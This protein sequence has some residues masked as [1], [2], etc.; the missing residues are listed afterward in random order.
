M[1]VILLEKVLKLGDPGDL[2]NVRKGYARNFLIPQ[3]KA[4]RADD[5]NKAEYEQ[6]RISLE[7]AEEAR[8]NEALEI[9]GKLKSIEVSISTAASEEGSLYGSIGTREIQEAILLL[10][11]EIEKSSIR[12]PKGTLKE[13]GSYQVDIE[14][15]PEVVQP[16]TIQVIEKQV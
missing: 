14:L 5:Q 6:R 13:L 9:S 10:G 7:K 11:L 4:I 16:I 8:K 12:L 3:G 2:V 1:E 15:H